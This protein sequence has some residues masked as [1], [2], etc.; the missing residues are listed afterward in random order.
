VRRARLDVDHIFF[1]TECRTRAMDEGL[2][3]RFGRAVLRIRIFRDEGGGVAR[4]A[5]IVFGSLGGVGHKSAF[6]RIGYFGAELMFVFLLAS[7]L[8]LE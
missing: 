4:E 2:G 1:M 7:V 3:R 5:R 6:R 8:V